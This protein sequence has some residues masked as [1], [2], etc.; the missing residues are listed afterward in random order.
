MLSHFITAPLFLFAANACWMKDTMRFGMFVVI[1][2]DTVLNDWIG[3]NCL[4]F[5]AA[6]GR[7]YLDDTAS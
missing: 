6:F 7:P 4:E 1:M 5:Y 2:E 3:S